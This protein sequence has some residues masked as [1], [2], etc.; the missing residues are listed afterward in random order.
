M[1]E[2][3]ITTRDNYNLIG[4]HFKPEESNKKVVLI[5]PATGVKQ[6][7]YF[8]FANFL[9]SKGFDVITYDY[10]GIGLSKNKSLK[11][12]DASMKDWAQKDF[13]ALTEY[14]NQNFKQHN[15]ILIGHSFGGNSIGMAS[16]AGDFDAYI[17]IASQFGYWKYFNTIYKPVLLWVFYFI[18]PILSNLY[19]YFPSKVKQLGENLPKGVA[20]DW[21]T[22]ITHPNSMLELTNETGNYYNS[23][24]KPMLMISFSDD[25]MAPKKAVD[26]LSSRV[27]SNAIVERQHIKANK[28]KPIG[29]MNYF[30][31]Q[32]E[33]DLWNI[34]T[35]WIKT[36]ELK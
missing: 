26:E 28:S 10:R 4:Y 27:Y 30:R 3:Q 29:H 17:T 7:F 32:F 35:N 12:F 25:Q 16:N 1:K 6:R 22:L 34:P 18:M 36:L 31:K 14:L 19:G 5:N 13:G 23:V 21:I 8:K 33:S 15:K 2:I 20:K 9:S 11:E 24:K